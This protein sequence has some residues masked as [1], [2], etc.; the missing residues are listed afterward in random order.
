M[1]E[2]ELPRGPG[3]ENVPEPP[4]DSKNALALL[5][6]ELGK[7]AALKIVAFLD[8]AHIP[9]PAVRC[10][11]P[12]LLASF[13]MEMPPEAFEKWMSAVLELTRQMREQN[14]KPE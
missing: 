1:P 6:L 8:E 10:S 2:P 11:F 5:G 14:P 7:A 12:F 9:V 13:T 3:E 4:F